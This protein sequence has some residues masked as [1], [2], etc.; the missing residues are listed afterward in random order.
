LT[1]KPVEVP[2]MNL[3][4]GTYTIMV[5]PVPVIVTPTLEVKV[6]F[7]GKI[8]AAFSTGF[9]ENATLIANLLYSGGEWQPTSSFTKDFQ[10]LPPTVEGTASFKAYGGPK[11]NILLYGMVAPYINLN[12]SLKAEAGVQVQT[13]PCYWFELSTGLFAGVGVEVKILSKVL[14]G[15]YLEVINFYEPLISNSSSCAPNIE[16][17]K[18]NSDAPKTSSRVVTLNNTCIGNP[19]EYMASELSSFSG[20]NWQPYSAAPSF[21]LSSVDGA[22][23]VYFK[24]K[25]SYGESVYETDAIT[26]DVGG[27]G[28]VPTVSTIAINGGVSTTTSRTVTLD[29]TCTGIPAEFMASESSTFSG[30]SWQPYSISPSFTITSSGD[31]LKTVWIK[32]RN[33][34]GESPAKSDTITLNTATGQTPTVNTIAING[35]LSTTSS[36][37]VALN[38]TCTG[39]PTQYMASEYQDFNVSS[40]WQPYSTAPS[41]YITSP[42]DGMKTVWFKVRNS[43]G[44]S[45]ALSDT[46]TLNPAIFN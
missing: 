3:E 42:A 20:A 14:A 9:T 29:N 4:F 24:V 10:F 40:G 27:A 1:Q 38:N 43:Y 25:N 13:P 31:G 34:F 46:I 11:L 32:V 41:F 39:T 23:R 5:G 18:I 35:G 33:N 2:L 16:F 37:T 36:R 22:K 8:T 6:G 28:E 30:A 44:E 17:F 26:L 15:K 45:A 19:T 12:A 7:D 21:T